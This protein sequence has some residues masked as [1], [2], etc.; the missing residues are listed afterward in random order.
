MNYSSIGFDNI[1][2]M[3]TENKYSRFPILARLNAGNYAIALHINNL[4]TEE[5]YFY[6]DYVYRCFECG[7]NKHWK[8]LGDIDF[9]KKEFWQFSN[10]EELQADMEERLCTFLK[11]REQ[12]LQ[13][14]TS[15]CTEMET[16]T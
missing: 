1:E 12:F 3:C 15:S 7:D 6:Q 8:A 14:N 16:Q 5:P 10:D 11:R 13:E 9:N 2:G 4:A